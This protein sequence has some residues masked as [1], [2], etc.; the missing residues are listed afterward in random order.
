VDSQS[1]EKLGVVGCSFEKHL[2]EWGFQTASF[3]PSS[4][5]STLLFS[6]ATNHWRVI[7]ESGFAGLLSIAM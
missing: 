7:L 5:F 3:A 2:A 1:D 4:S 6:H